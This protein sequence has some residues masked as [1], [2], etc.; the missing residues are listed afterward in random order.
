MNFELKL[1]YWIVKN[2]NTMSVFSDELGISRTNIS[3]YLNG[4]RKPGY[5][6]FKKIK[7]MGCDLNWLFENE[8]TES[9][10]LV[11]KL[12]D[13]NLLLL[14][15]ISSFIGNIYLNLLLYSKFKTPQPITNSQTFRI[16]KS[17]TTE[18]SEL[19]SK[20]YFQP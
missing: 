15:F 2:V 5:R 1:K 4:I 9:K 17:A 19:K 12:K 16:K 11:K 7:K 6:F 3:R 8:T 18:Q 14:I 10:S 20:Q 13:N